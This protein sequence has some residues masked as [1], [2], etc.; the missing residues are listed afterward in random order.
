MGYKEFKGLNLPEIDQ[1]ISEFWKKATVFEKSIQN[2][3]DAENF[4]FYEG[5]P[6]ANGMPG[7]HHV[8]ARTIKDIFCRYKT[9]QGYKVERKA[10]W[11]THGL[12][13][14]LGVEKELG[15]TKEDIGKKVSVAEYNQKCREAVMRYTDVWNDLTRKMG[16]W[17]D[18]DHP[19]VTYEN[20][21]IASLWYLLKKLHSKNLLYKGYTIQPYSPAAGTG[22]SSHELNQPGCY[23]D[24]KDTSVTA[25]FEVERNAASKKLFDTEDKVYLLAWTTTP[26]T[27]PSNA[28]LA[29]GEKIE[30][31][32]VK[33]YNKYNFEPVS[34]VLA[35]ALFS[36]YFLDA[37][38][39]DKE[40]TPV[41]FPEN[42]SFEAL[43]E[44]T[45][46]Q[47]DQAFKGSKKP[48]FIVETFTGKDLLDIQYKQLFPFV[49][50]KSD[51]FRVIAGDFVTTDD[52]TGIV[53]IAPTFGADDAR[54]GKIAGIA[55]I[56]VTRGKAEV[57]LVNRQ[58]K[59]VEEMGEFAGRYV[60]QEY[61]TDSELQAEMKAQDVEDEKKLKN[62]DVLLSIWL[63]EQ[64]KAFHVEKYEH[65]YPHCWRTDKPVLYYPLDSWF[66]KTTAI[67]DRLIELNKTINWKPESTG[68]GRFGNWLENLQDWNLSRSRY[69][70]TPLPIWRTEDGEEEICIGSIEELEKEI[71]KSI[72][73]GFMKENLPKDFD[74]HK[75]FV[76]DIILV[77]PSGRKMTREADL[78]DVWFDSGAMPFAQW[79]SKSEDNPQFKANFPADFIAEGVD[80]TRGWFFTLHAI[81]TMCFDSVAYKNVISNG[82]LLD[83]NG[84]KMSKRLGNA[85]D[86]FKTIT[87]YGADATRWYII[88][89]AKPW[90]NLR[91]NTEGI[92]EVQR[93]FFGTLYNTYSF[94]ALYANIDGF[95]Y[96]EDEIPLE[97]RPEIDCWILS[98]LHTLIEEVQ[99]AYDD[100]EP[101]NAARAIQYFVDEHLS[102]WYVR[103]CRRRFWKGEYS[104]DKIAAYQ[105]LYTCLNTL[106]GLIAPVAPF[107]ADFLFKN[108][109]QTTAKENEISVHLSNFPK[110]DANIID[111]DLEQR[112]FLAQKASSLILS[113]RKR[114]NIKVRQPLNKVL[115]PVADKAEMQ[116]FQKVEDLILS[117]VNV[118]E[119]EYVEN[120]RG[121]VTKNIKP[122]FKL[123]GKKL[124]PK[125]KAV[126]QALAAFSQEDISKIEQEGFTRLD[127]DGE[128]IDLKRGEVEITSEDIPGWL[129]AS[130]EG[131][132]V[133]LDINLTDDLVDEGHAREFVNKIQNLRKD[134]KF[135]VTDRIN[136]TLDGQ[137]EIKSALIRF[138]EYICT[139]VLAENLSENSEIKNGT[140]IDVNGV[141]VIVEISKN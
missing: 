108:L 3:S 92:K 68:T 129:V 95:E 51:A 5:P 112:M 4:V 117:E 29:V 15:I 103:L 52:G 62:T 30:Y 78:I 65:S 54:V 67:K 105:T 71:E 123:L 94:F 72:E 120:T 69:W 75:P 48:G 133:A 56:T 91:F 61:L 63:K 84:Q 124:G 21:Y 34:V 64:H 28:A 49:A 13:V 41:D 23:R 101:T 31:V 35:K 106:S 136:I 131:V 19:Y 100:Y 98:A 58:G 25:Q 88:S 37:E 50:P 59:F 127:I 110:S 9:M 132:T 39:L 17:V 138:K 18:M 90:E 125:M 128:E 66:I 140:T 89:N 79:H 27:L 46:Q 86:P 121:I 87:K 44:N 109:N 130:D 6:S 77:S 8:M 116:R 99:K 102:N 135:E 111:T 137:T 45:L 74:L 96:K 22:L 36:T 43:G 38:K 107:F 114:E 60:K 14:E 97:K 2:R 16:Y 115:I 113:L 1:S 26:W 139:E 83:K 118:K 7:I 20:D 70:G 82:L 85:V 40:N 24:V 47:I 73:A 80:Q 126:S 122:N 55:G 53:H 10:G 81:G 32:K 33:T 11:D 93:K 42:K 12:P 134:L 57:P 104:E 119:V 141:P 76:D